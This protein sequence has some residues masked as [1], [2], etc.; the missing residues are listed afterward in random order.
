[1]KHCDYPQ[2]RRIGAVDRIA[3]DVAL[4]VGLG[5]ARDLVDRTLLGPR[6]GRRVIEARAEVIEAADPLP[7]RE[8]DVDRGPRSARGTDRRRRVRVSPR[9][10]AAAAVGHSDRGPE[11]IDE[12]PLLRAR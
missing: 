1:M 4:A 2:T 6:G 12:D 7:A 8:L 11:G 5:Q 3:S 10:R 9:Q